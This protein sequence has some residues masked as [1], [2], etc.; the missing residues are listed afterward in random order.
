MERTQDPPPSQ[1]SAGLAIAAAIAVTATSACAL[2]TAVPVGS[3]RG[4]TD[5]SLRSPSPPGATVRPWQ[6]APTGGLVRPVMPDPKLDPPA[7]V[8]PVLVAYAQ[9]VQR[10]ACKE[11]EKAP[12]SFEWTLVE[13]QAKLYD[14]EYREIGSH[15]AGPAWQ[16]VDGSRVVKK[17]LIASVPA[18]ASDGVPWLLVEVESSGKGGLSGIRYVQRID[19]VGGAAPPGGCDPRGVS[20]SPRGEPTDAAHPGGKQDVEYRATYV[21]YGARPKA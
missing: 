16:L 4:E 10:Y 3:P 5:T 1:R 9:G 11:K 6:V 7:D 17:Q 20:V 2:Q 21:F 15:S 13:P 12:G 19:T 14:A 18:L 8:V